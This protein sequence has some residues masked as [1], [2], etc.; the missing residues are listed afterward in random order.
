MEDN[1]EH[2]SND[3]LVKSE[4]T[5]QDSTGS[6]SGKRSSFYLDNDANKALTFYTEKTGMKVSHVINGLLRLLS[7]AEEKPEYEQLYREVKK[8]FTREATER[9]IEYLNANIPPALI[10]SD[11]I[12]VECLERR[13]LFWKTA[14]KGKEI[15][16]IAIC[17]PV[18]AFNF[19][20]AHSI[21]LKMK[22]QLKELVVVITHGVDLLDP[23]LV[24]N[25][26]GL[27]IYLEPLYGSIKRLED[28]LAAYKI[29]RDI[30]F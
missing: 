15:G 19:L 12:G 18:S 29:N 25:V 28:I 22:H 10:K 8:F 7:D 16:F 13:A 6:L 26:S 23:E 11:K 21:D 9:A 2:N 30:P 1:K 20:V 4:R 24:E 14:E 3:T 27:S 5:Q 17:E